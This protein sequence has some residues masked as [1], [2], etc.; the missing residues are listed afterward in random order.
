MAQMHVNGAV[1]ATNNYG[2]EGDKTAKQ[3]LVNAC[4]LFSYPGA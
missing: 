1:Q 3:F 4:S 2:Q